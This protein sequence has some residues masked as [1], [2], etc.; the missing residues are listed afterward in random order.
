MAASIFI[1]LVGGFTAYT[2]LQKMNSPIKIVKAFEDAVERDQPKEL[3]NLLNK[4]QQEMDVEEADAKKFIAYFK[5]NPDILA[6]TKKELEKSVQYLENDQITS[7]KNNHF[8]Y[9]GE[10]KKKWGII[11][12][13]GIGFQP[14]YLQISSNQ[15][16][17]SV[18][19]NG[20][21]AGKLKDGEVTKFG[22]L[23]PGKHEVEGSFKGEYTTVTAKEVIESSNQDSHK[24]P[25]EFDLTGDEI[26]LTSNYENAIVFIDGKTTN[27]TVAQLESFGPVSLDG[28]MEIQAE[29]KVQGKTLKSETVPLD[30]SYIDLWIDDSPLLEAEARK[31]ETEARK[32]E[33]EAAEM[34]AIESAQEDIKNVVY[35]HYQDISS[36]DY[37][38]A[39]DLFSKDRKGK[40]KLSN[41]EKGLTDTIRDEVTY[42]TVESIDD[43]TATVSFEMVSEDWKDEE[44]LTQT[45]QGKWH[46]TKESTGWKL[47]KPEI[48]LVGPDA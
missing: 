42:L 39:Y 28:K 47:H 5:E 46:L 11:Q 22:P 1:L 10:H 14:I 24:F 34:D 20:K 12:Q 35:E 29:L 21:D 7:S 48:K 8:L 15:P 25:I 27:K 43:S 31:A 32:A 9:V 45:W 41:W 38:A 18:S 6:E 30:S 13:Y 16:D 4:G 19:I 37:T 40:V 26:N 33:A 3:A 44:T 23:L 17:T 36:G 2:V